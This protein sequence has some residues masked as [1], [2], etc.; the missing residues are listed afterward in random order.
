MKTTEPPRSL[1]FRI[2]TLP[3]VLLLSLVAKAWS[4]MISGKKG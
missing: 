1:A 3:L 4:L 2:L